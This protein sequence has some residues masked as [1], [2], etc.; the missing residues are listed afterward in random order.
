MCNDAHV[1]L[2]TSLWSL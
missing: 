1:K 2:E